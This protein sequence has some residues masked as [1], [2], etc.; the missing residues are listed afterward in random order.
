MG[1]RQATRA[2]AALWEGPCPSLT[3]LYWCTSKV[4]CSILMS[5]RPFLQA[6]VWLYERE[7]RSWMARPQRSPFCCWLEVCPS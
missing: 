2:T 5:S 6:A 3:S 7:A 1:I 4:A